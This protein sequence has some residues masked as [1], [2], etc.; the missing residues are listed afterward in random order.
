[1]GRVTAIAKPADRLAKTATASVAR[2][3]AAR[4]SVC[5]RLRAVVAVG[6]G[7]VGGLVS[8]RVGLTTAVGRTKSAGFVDCV[9]GGALLFVA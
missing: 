3:M 8:V 2:G 9:C 6:A 4:L 1:M 5:R 7:P